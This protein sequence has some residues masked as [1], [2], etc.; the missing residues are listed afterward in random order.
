MFGWLVLI[1]ALATPLEHPSIL[2]VLAMVD[3]G[4]GEDVVVARVER[5]TGVPVLAGADIAALKKRGVPDSVL[6]ALV[7]RSQP[8]SVNGAPSTSSSGGASIRVQ[9]ESG[10]PV[11]YWEVVV[12]GRTVAE[13]GEVR[14]P[15]VEDAAELPARLALRGPETL[16]EGD[17]AP[18]RHLVYAGFAVTRGTSRQVTTRVRAGEVDRTL[19]QNRGTVCNVDPGELCIVTVR[20]R[21]DGS[22]WLPGGPAVYVV[23][24]D[25]LVVER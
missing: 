1:L 13:D 12:N 2:E 4:V 15:I 9:A 5:L 20:F 17:V 14:P 3:A 25:A 24:Y 8:G 18:G 11:S 21:K 19:E 10:F 16:F 6:L 7:E 22:G 23:S